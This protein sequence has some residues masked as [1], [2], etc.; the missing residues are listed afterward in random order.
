M[1][2]VSPSRKNYTT[3]SVGSLH[4]HSGGERLLLFGDSVSRVQS[5][6][7]LL[8]RLLL[9]LQYIVHFVVMLRSHYHIVNTRGDLA[10]E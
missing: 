5:H 10:L 2:Y 6:S 9:R 4:Y 7:S 1:I 3:S 8:Q